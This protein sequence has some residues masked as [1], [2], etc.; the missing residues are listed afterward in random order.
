MS[1]QE[2]GPVAGLDTA[3][4]GAENFICS[5]LYCEVRHHVDSY[6]RVE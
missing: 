1:G 6:W 2:T 4:E 3:G 5:G